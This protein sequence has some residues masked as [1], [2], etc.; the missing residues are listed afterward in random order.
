[1]QQDAKNIIL[2]LDRGIT[3]SYYKVLTDRIKVYDNIYIFGPAHAEQKIYNRL[4]SD[5][6]FAKKSINLESS[7][8]TQEPTAG[9][10][11]NIFSSAMRFLLFLL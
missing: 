8:K 6:L 9:K 11:K 1:M 3:N 10:I 5:Q 2:W 7:D 4:K